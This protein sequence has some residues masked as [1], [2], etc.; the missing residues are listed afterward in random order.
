MDIINNKL[1]MAYCADYPA[2][3]GDGQ[4][5]RNNHFFNARNHL[6]CK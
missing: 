2:D 4:E 1:P 3:D 5:R 6:D